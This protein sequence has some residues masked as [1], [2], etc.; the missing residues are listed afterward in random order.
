MIRALASL[1]GAFKDCCMS[2]GR[3]D[4]VNRN[5]YF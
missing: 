3:F 4:G 5:E 1:D 2:S